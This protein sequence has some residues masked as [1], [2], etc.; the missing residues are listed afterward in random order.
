MTIENTLT[1]PPFV[2]KFQY[3]GC[4][5]VN[6]PVTRKRVYVT[7]DGDRLPSVTTILS[8]TKDMT[9]LNEWKKRVGDC[10]GKDTVIDAH[11]AH[12]VEINNRPMQ[13][14]VLHWPQ[15]LNHLIWSDDAHDELVRL[16]AWPATKP[17]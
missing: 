1:P 15:G 7:P 8:S 11:V 12:H 14:G 9:H 4:E 17:W 6:D 3:K 10:E 2:E 16:I 13:L 5:Q